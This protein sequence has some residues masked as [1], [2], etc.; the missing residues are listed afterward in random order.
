MDFIKGIVFDMDGTLLDSTSTLIDA[1]YSALS[2]FSDDVPK[3]EVAKAVKGSMPSDMLIKTFVGNAEADTIDKVKE[4]RA[5]AATGRLSSDSL[6][7]GVPYTLKE[8]H[9]MGIKLAIATGMSHDLLD[10]VAES[11]GLSKVVDAIISSD[12]VEHGKPA[13]DVI[14]EAF[15]RI[16]INPKEGLVVGDSE[17]DVLSGK[18]AGAITALVCS[19]KQVNTKADFVISNIAEILNLIK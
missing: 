9:V 5:R 17:N 8:L 15:R 18:G 14:I 4:L 6:F 13:P 7:T 12:E 1:W 2:S 16:G 19:D 3:E 11:K 10:V